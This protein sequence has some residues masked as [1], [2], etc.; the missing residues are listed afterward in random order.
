[1]F[2]PE[3]IRN[4]SFTLLPIGYNPEHVDTLLDAIATRVEA[5]EPFADLVDGTEVESSEVGYAPEEVA[6]FLAALGEHAEDASADVELD[7]VSLAPESS[8]RDDEVTDAGEVADIFNYAAA[9]EQPEWH[10]EST[11]VDLQVLGQAVHRTSETLGS[12]QSF[13]D[14][15]ISA[16][17]LA[18]ERQ[19][20][21]TALRCETLLSEAAAEAKTLTDAANAE[22]SRAHREAERENEKRQRELAKQLKQMQAD[23]D[24]AAAKLRSES[25]EYAAETRAAADRDR[26]DA[27]RTIENAIS[28][29]SA[30]AES[31]ERARQQLTPDRR[32]SDIAA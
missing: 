14:N 20:Q 4:A 6:D 16:M 26:Q 29:Q 23:A 31:L 21:E 24:A 25:E 3:S 8:V 10:P 12:L 13:I 7:E 19:A 9:P 11:P 22:I 1:L 2:D 15:E 27:Q 5:G 30:I 18:V 17:K 28:M 32:Q